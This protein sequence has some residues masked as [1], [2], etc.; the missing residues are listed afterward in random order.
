MKYKFKLSE[1]KHLPEQSDLISDRYKLPMSVD[2]AN[3]IYIEYDELYGKIQVYLEY[4]DGR[5][6]LV[7][8]DIWSP[9]PVLEINTHEDGTAV[10]VELWM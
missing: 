1:C 8:Q 10:K 7:D 3:I 9:D 6:V 2:G 5:K 4:T